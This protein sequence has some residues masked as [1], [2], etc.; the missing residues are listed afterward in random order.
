MRIANGNEFFTR[1]HS[2]AKRQLDVLLLMAVSHAFVVEFRYTTPYFPNLTYTRRIRRNGDA[3]RVGFLY[4]PLQCGSLSGSLNAGRNLRVNPRVLDYRALL[5]TM[6]Y[7]TRSEGRLD[8]LL[9]SPWY[10]QLWG[11]CIFGVVFYVA[12]HYGMSF[13]PACASPFWF[14]DT[15]LLCAL[16]LSPSQKWWIYIVGMLPIRLFSP[17]AHGIPIWFLLATYAIDSAKGILAAWALRRFI[18]N[19]LRLASVKDFGFFCI[20]VVLSVPAVSAFAGAGARYFLNSPFWPAW[21]QWFLGDAVTHAVLTPAALW[22]LFAWQHGIGKLSRARLLEAP[23]LALALILTIRLAF[24]SDIKGMDFPMSYFYAPIPLLFWAAVRFGMSGASGATIVLT[25][26]TVHAAIQGR[27]PFFGKSPSEAALILQ[28]YLLFRTAPL[29]LVA[30]LIQQK[31]DAEHSLRESE[32]RFRIMADTAPVLIW[33]SG[34][35]K[36]C[37]F[38]NRGW[39]DFTGRTMEQ[40]LGNGWAEGVHPQDLEHCVQ[41]YH[42]AFDARQPFEMEYRLRR[43]DGEYRWVLDRGVPRHD[44]EGDFLGYIGSVMDLTDR[45]RAEEARQDLV[46]ASRLAV[47]GEFTAMIAHELNQPLHAILTNIDAARI[48][49]DVK[50]APVAEMRQILADI[51]AD[52]LRANEAIRHIRALVSKREMEMQLL[53]MNATVSEV[54]R[55]A[56]GDAFRRGVRLHEDC[57][58]PLATVQGDVVHLQHVVLNLIVNAMDA[59]KDNAESDRHLFVSTTSH[60]DLVEVAVKDTGHGIPVGDLARVFNSFFTTKRDG[61]GIGLSMCR[62]IVQMHSGIIWA[63][64]N[65]DGKGTTFR[66][67][68]PAVATE[69]ASPTTAGQQGECLVGGA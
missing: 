49:L 50:I 44:T 28:E 16:L 42:S 35:D 26:I 18:R 55:L 15:V 25:S 65:R 63:E 58:A 32:E 59:M 47:M 60:D 68:L 20:I 1:R 46:H 69:A 2:C 11:L 54:V 6:V 5:T 37:N 38:F 48:L 51:R 53:D 43:R 14:P 31:E 13:S 62:S 61:M 40:E 45:K 17:V 24:A 30:I 4:T 12:Y 23:A 10:R 8:R 34:T 19:P 7:S 57:R 41:I 3:R 9:Q 29:Y 36:L 39:L 67:S 56:K 21:Q 66:F 64:N 22:C 52:N 33:M 27:G